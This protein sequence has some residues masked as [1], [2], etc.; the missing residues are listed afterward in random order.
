MPTYSDRQEII[1]QH[2]VDLWR[3]VTTNDPVSARREGKTH[4]LSEAGVMCHFVGRQSVEAPTAIGRSE[5]DNF[6]TR[7]EYH[8]PE[9]VE[10]GAAWVI[11][12]RTLDFDGNETQH[13]N[14]VWI[15]Q[16]RAKDVAKLGDRD[17]GKRQVEVVES[18]R[19]PTVISNY[20]GGL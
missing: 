12:N 9:D 14:R 13:Y 1:Y 2:E 3:P 17:A 7:D 4:V 8:F 15:T 11:V 10:I 6:Y 20:Y 16:G 19:A 18:P 5:S